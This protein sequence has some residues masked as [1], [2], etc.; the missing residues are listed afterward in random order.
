[1]VLSISV[2]S[3]VSVFVEQCYLYSSDEETMI[4]KIS[5]NVNQFDHEI[6]TTL[7]IREKLIIRY[8]IFS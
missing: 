4:T 8:A 3:S 5:D 7:D 2:V 1:M 6:G